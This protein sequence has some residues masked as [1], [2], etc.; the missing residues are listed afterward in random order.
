MIVNLRFRVT[1]TGVLKLPM[2]LLAQIVLW[3]AKLHT[4][5]SLEFVG[6]SKEHVAEESIVDWQVPQFDSMLYWRVEQPACTELQ[7]NVSR[8]GVTCVNWTSFGGG[9]GSIMWGEI[10]GIIW[11]RNLS[12]SLFPFLSLS[13]LWEYWNLLELHV[14]KQAPVLY[15]IYRAITCYRNCCWIDDIED[16]CIRAVHTLHRP[17]N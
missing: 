12:L 14:F 5:I 2:M 16:S 11:N 10:Q 15:S 9:R 1:L 13:Q 6:S 4:V 7:L 8:F 3:T 17:P